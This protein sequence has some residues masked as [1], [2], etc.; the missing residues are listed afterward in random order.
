[1]PSTSSLILS[2]LA[3]LL[4][5]TYVQAATYSLHQNN[6]GTDFLSNFVWETTEN[7]SGGRV[8][9]TTQSDALSANLTYAHGDTFIMRVDDTTTLSASDAGR[10]SV[11][12]KSNEQYTTHVA[13]F[14]IRHMP[15]G[16]GT[17]PA[18]WEVDDTVGVA[19]GEVDIIEG[20]NDLSPSYS[21]MHTPNTC[22]MPTTGR[23]Q[24]GTAVGNDCSSTTTQS[25][26]NNGCSVSSPYSSTYGP[27]FNADGGGWFVVERTSSAVSIWFWERGDGTVP[28]AVSGG[29]STID[30][31]SW[32]TTPIAYFP[33]SSTCDLSTN[34]QSHNI[35][36]NT[37][38][39]GPWAG[40]RYSASG[41]PGTCIDY[42]N[43]NPSAF[44]NAY[45]DFAA[46]RV[47]L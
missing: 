7:P 42:V 14:D 5:A 45:W 9:Y 37:M 34:L 36:I 43:S 40:S 25:D 30:T 35:I 1:M 19:H 46:L 16:C 44:S 20:V 12:I 26:G 38:L 39:C 28:A 41:C 18:I 15:Q 31:G 3:S 10:K 11:R 23:N 27:T 24:K 33:S 8:A 4:S 22:T 21:T 29:A 2:T 32:S 17:W 47:Y 13:V 6:V